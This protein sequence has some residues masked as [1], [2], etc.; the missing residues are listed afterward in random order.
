MRL[1]LKTT[2]VVSGFAH[3][4]GGIVSD[5]TLPIKNIKADVESIHWGFPVF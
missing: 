3:S 4:H 5:P 2:S 1:P